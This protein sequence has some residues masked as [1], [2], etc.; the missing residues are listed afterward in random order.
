[1]EEYIIKYHP[2]V[3]SVDIPSLDNAFAKRIKKSI[4]EK[5]TTNPNIFGV[6]LRSELAGFKKLRVGNYRVIFNVESHIV[7]VYLIDHRRSA[8][9]EISRRI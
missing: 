4:E 1:M 7:F 9:K 6:P 5:L 8:Y 2:K 3:V